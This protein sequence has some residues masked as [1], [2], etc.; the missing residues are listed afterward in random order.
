TCTFL[1]SDVSWGRTKTAPRSTGA[2]DDGRNQTTPVF[3]ARAALGKCPW[4]ASRGAAGLSSRRGDRPDTGEGAR[5]HPG[6]FERK[7]HVI[8]E[9]I[10]SHVRSSQL[11]HLVEAERDRNLAVEDRQQHGELLRLR[12]NLLDGGGMAL[13]GALLDEHGLADLEFHLGDGG[14]FR[15]GLGGRSLGSGGLGLTLLEDRGQH[16]ED[17]VDRQ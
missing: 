10:S 3:H 8:A 7:S 12:T 11:R 15:G 16:R 14:R 6:P 17:L 2:S 13:E 9:A 4:P 5:N 1:T